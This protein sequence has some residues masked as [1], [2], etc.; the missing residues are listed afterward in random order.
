M[1]INW[2]E[3][4]YNSTSKAIYP[5]LDFSG[6]SAGYYY[7]P[8]KKIVGDSGIRFAHFSV[9]HSVCPSGLVSYKLFKNFIKPFTSLTLFGGMRPAK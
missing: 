8:L 4:L 9:C 2:V 1:G 5:F 7:P 3:L 6:D